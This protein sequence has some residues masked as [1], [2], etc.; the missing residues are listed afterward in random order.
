MK[1]LYVNFE[2]SMKLNE[3]ILTICGIFHALYSWFF[4]IVFF[5][6]FD[7]F[8]QQQQHCHHHTNS[9][10]GYAIEPRLKQI[11]DEDAGHIFRE[12]TS[13][14]SISD[15]VNRINKNQYNYRDEVN[16]HQMF[17]QFPLGIY[18]NQYKTEWMWKSDWYTQWNLKRKSTR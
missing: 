12:A 2:I 17:H 16:K 8:L 9:S 7:C 14:S 6:Y 4:R 5:F 13:A 18:Q 11:Q 1:Y 10:T 15:S 3:K